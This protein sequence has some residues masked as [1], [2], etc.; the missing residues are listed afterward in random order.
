MEFRNWITPVV[1]VGLA[2]G[3]VLAGGC[4][5]GAPGGET[6]WDAFLRDLETERAVGVA[7]QR[8]AAEAEAPASELPPPPESRELSRAGQVTI[9]PESVIQVS[10]REDPGLDGSYRVNDIYAV[11]LGYVGPVF[12]RNS[13]EDEAAAKIKEVLENRFFNTATVT[14]R[15]L[16]A[17]YDRVA[18]R[19]AVNSPGT[20]N[21]GSGD[22]ISLNESLL[23]AGHVTGGIRNARLRIVRGGMQ[24]AVS[25]SLDGEVYRLVDDA[26]RPQVPDVNLWNNDVVYVYTVVQTQDGVSE[27]P[28]NVL[29]LGEVK[30]R[31]VYRFEPNAPATMLHLIFRMDG[32]PEFA[33]PSAIRIIRRDDA[34][35]QYEF[36]VDARTILRDGDPEKDVLLENGDRVI[37]PA[38]R[39]GLFR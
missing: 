32:F 7:R 10:V 20:I 25:A 30:R 2:L 27:S 31:G 8:T 12:I 24:S 22:H 37:V 26:G 13:T 28:K 9:Q 21:I 38:R 17:S 36:T 29:V 6:D 16:R 4:R 19:G 11:D 34:G 18:V 33:D 23:R 3:M 15:I 39:F 5:S 35:R 1:S 14:V